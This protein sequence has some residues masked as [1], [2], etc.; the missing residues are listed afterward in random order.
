[1]HPGNGDAPAPTCRVE[2][3]NSG[4]TAKVQPLAD[5][6]RVRGKLP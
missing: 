1:M 2:I 5:M 6:Q 3:L 4:G